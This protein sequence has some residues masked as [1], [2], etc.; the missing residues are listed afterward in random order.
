M[1]LLS[2]KEALDRLKAYSIKPYKKLDQY[3][4][5]SPQYIRRIVDRAEVGEEDVVLEVGAGVGFLTVALAD[6]AGRVLAVEKDRRLVSILREELGLYDNIDIIEGDILASDLRGFNKVASNPPYGIS[7]K[8]VY[9]L[10]E[11]L[12]ARA[13]M[14]FQE[15]FALRLAAK[16]GSRDYGLASALSS[17]VY[18]LRIGER[19][20]KHAFSPPSPFRSVIVTMVR[21]REVACDEI[22]S[23]IPIGKLI[24]TQKKRTLRKAAGDVMGISKG[25]PLWKD[26]KDPDKRVVDLTPE[27]VMEAC[28]LLCSSKAVR[29]LAVNYSQLTS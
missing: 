11:R 1:T 15:D 17:Y 7:T 27:E 20:P 2:R 14:T 24:F 23:L 29:K 18:D 3:F 21:K 12:P 4:M 25:D 22:R 8:L 10:L 13:V 26:V 16:H 5:V 6:R 19:V 9:W 28:R